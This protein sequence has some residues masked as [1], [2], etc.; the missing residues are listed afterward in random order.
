MRGVDKDWHFTVFRGEGGIAGAVFGIEMKEL[1]SGTE[2]GVAVDA[3]G[4]EELKEVEAG[5]GVDGYVV[6]VAR[7]DYGGENSSKGF[8]LGWHYPKG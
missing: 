4:F 2:D 6:M 7:S 8:C 5:C 1:A 3:V